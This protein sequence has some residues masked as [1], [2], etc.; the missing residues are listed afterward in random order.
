M[1]L[2]DPRS[3]E[4]GVD[5]HG[6]WTQPCTVAD[7]SCIVLEYDATTESRSMHDESECM[8]GEVRSSTSTIDVEDI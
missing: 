5:H 6:E 8:M 4:A 1:I 2:D 7:Y 3:M